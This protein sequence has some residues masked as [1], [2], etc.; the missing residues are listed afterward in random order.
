MLY[1]DFE[2]GKEKIRESGEGGRSYLCVLLIIMYC[3]VFLVSLFWF[4]INILKLV[5]S[6]CK[7][8]LMIIIS[9]RY[10]F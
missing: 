5:K 10:I 3:Y 9:F 1:D 2:E 6:I 7:R 4:C 8:D